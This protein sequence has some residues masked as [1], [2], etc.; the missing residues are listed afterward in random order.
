MVSRTR[1]L[2]DFGNR[3]SSDPRFF[4]FT[5][6]KEDTMVDLT[7]HFKQGVAEVKSS[8]ILNFAKYT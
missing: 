7:K 2:A 8:A 5:V 1:A 6:A 3:G 4:V